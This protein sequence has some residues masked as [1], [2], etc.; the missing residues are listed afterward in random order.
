M[1][2][3]YVLTLAQSN[4]FGIFLNCSIYVEDILRTKLESFQT[5]AHT[6]ACMDR[7]GKTTYYIHT[8]IIMTGA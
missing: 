3:D 1:D 5:Q 4:D 2:L 8:S 7:Q 6:H